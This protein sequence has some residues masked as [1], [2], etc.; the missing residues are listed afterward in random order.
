[1]TRRKAARPSALV[2]RPDGSGGVVRAS[3][4]VPEGLRDAYSAVAEIIEAPSLGEAPTVV[5]VTITD[6]ATG[7]VVEVRGDRVTLPLDGNADYIARLWTDARQIVGAPKVGRPVGS[8][9]TDAG[10]QAAVAAMVRAGRR[11][12]LEG[13]AASSGTFTYDQLRYFLRANGRRLS[14]YL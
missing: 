9:V 1:M 3:L 5:G 10:V 8:P 14:D 2:W 4:V 11:V 13:V 7:A 6:L 12:T